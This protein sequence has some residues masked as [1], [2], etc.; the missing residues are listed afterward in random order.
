MAITTVL[1]Y[2]FVTGVILPFVL[3]FAVLFAI[4]QKTK[5]LGGEN[6]GIDLIVSAA[7]SLIAVSF[8]SPAIVFSKIIPFF[9]V[10]VIVI[11]MLLLIFSFSE[12]KDK[13]ELSKGMKNGIIGAFIVVMAIVLIR[14][15]GLW[16]WLKNTSPSLLWNI[17]FLIVIAAVITIMLAIGKKADK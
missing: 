11:F 8:A 7:L 10:A 14:A 16:A 6:K 5:L 4:L 13:L 15:S 12:G 17:I 2:P 9:A 3:I 1:S